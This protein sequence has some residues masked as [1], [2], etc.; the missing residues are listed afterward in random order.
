MLATIEVFIYIVFPAIQLLAWWNVHK[1]NRAVYKK[2]RGV[3]SKVNGR[4]DELRAAK[5]QLA[6]ERGRKEGLA[7]AIAVRKAGEHR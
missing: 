4:L 3:D 5:E 1:H 2:R 6:Y 7:E